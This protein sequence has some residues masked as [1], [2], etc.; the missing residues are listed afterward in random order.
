MGKSPAEP[1]VAEEFRPYFEGLRQG[2][3][4][5][6]RCERCLRF[7]WYPMKLCPHCRSAQIAWTAVTGPAKVFTWT[8]V[9]HA[10]DPG[11]TLKPPYVV[12]LIEFDDAPGVRL[13]ANLEGLAP[14]QAAIGLAVRPEFSKAGH[15]TRVT[16][17]PAT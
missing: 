10:F 6:P 16:F 11:F 15:D 13:V 8:E 12:A 5:F 9:H 4:R 1:A 14:G 3:L 17:R 2:E 7:H